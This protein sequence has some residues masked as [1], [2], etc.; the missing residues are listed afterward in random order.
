[1]SALVR[2]GL[3]AV[4]SLL[5]ASLAA[6]QTAREAEQPSPRTRT[7]PMAALEGPAAAAAPNTVTIAGVSGR[8]DVR[9]RRDAPWTAAAAGMVLSDSAEV[10]T[11]T[12]GEHWVQIRIGDTQLYT[13]SRGSYLSVRQAVRRAGEA[14]TAMDLNYGFIKVEVDSTRLANNVRIETPDATIAVSGTGLFV[15][16]MPGQPTRTGGLRGNTGLISLFSP[17][18]IA[19]LAGEQQADAATPDPARRQADAR[20]VDTADLRSR[21]PDEKSLAKRSPGGGDAAAVSLGAEPSAIAG[22]ASMPEKSQVVKKVDGR[23]VTAI[24]VTPP[25][26]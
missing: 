23:T 14:A 15:Y 10:R 1:M 3:G 17:A 18:G 9:A 22:A 5:T 12:V 26:R 25:P 13:I 8:A 16:S 2:V 11:G 20:A 6:G 4:V 7:A 19:T 21:E 24:S